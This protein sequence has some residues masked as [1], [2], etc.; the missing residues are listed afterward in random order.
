MRSS[1]CSGASPLDHPVQHRTIVSIRTDITCVLGVG[2]EEDSLQSV[3][4]LVPKAPR[5]DVKRIEE[6]DGK[7]QKF[8]ARLVDGEDFRLGLPS[9]SNRR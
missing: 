6:L 1:I 5:K 9:D 8:V 4:R 2:S 3:I 7:T